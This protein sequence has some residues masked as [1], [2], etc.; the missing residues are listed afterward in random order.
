M[1]VSLPGPDGQSPLTATGLVRWSRARGLGRR[2]AALG[3][4]W[5]PIEGSGRLHLEALLE[6]CWRRQGQAPTANGS[7]R[8]L[9]SRRAAWWLAAALSAAGVWWARE[10]HVSLLAANERLHRRLHEQQDRVVQLTRREVLLQQ[11]LGRLDAQTR[12]LG[13]LLERLDSDVGRMRTSY[14]RVREERQELLDRIAAL[15]ARRDEL[16]K[17]LA[18]LPDVLLAVEEAI[19]ARQARP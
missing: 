15:E 9:R 3:L 5:L 1:T 6:T 13:G 18:L 16:L 11:E 17:R 14:D 12:A 10:R 7:R 4:E 8:R 2:W 19:E